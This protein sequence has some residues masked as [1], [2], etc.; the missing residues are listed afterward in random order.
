MS[1]KKSHKSE[2]CSLRENTGPCHF[3][4]NARGQT[5]RHTDRRKIYT[6]RPTFREKFNVMRKKKRERIFFARKSFR[7]SADR[8]KWVIN[9]QERIMLLLSRDSRDLIR[10]GKPQNNEARPFAIARKMPTRSSLVSLVSGREMFSQSIRVYE[11]ASLME[12][13]VGMWL[14]KKAY[15]AHIQIITGGEN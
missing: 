6:A 13:D 1:E 5:D 3:P 14:S 2:N 8:E 7:F 12:T 4:R 9:K 11:L 10:Q 15:T